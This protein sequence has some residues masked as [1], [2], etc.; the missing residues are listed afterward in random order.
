MHI[1][2]RAFLRRTSS[3]ASFL[4]LSARAHMQELFYASPVLYKV[5]ALCV[6]TLYLGLKKMLF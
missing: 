5:V 3:P 6:K 2:Q 1:A 4:L